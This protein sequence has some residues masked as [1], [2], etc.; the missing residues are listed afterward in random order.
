[1]SGAISAA[2]GMAPAF[3]LLAVALITGAGFARRQV[4]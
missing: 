1:M 4:K 3:W 2:F